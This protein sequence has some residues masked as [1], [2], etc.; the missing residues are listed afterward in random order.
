MSAP[1]LSVIALEYHS[2]A[3]IEKCV[4]SIHKAC[5]NISHE[6]IIS[7][8]SCYNTEKQTALK[9]AYPDVIWLFN[10]KNGGFSYGMNQGLH[11]AQGHYLLTIN[12][13]VEMQNSPEALINFMEA[14][15]DVGIAGPQIINRKG[16]IQDSCRPYVSLPRLISRTFSRI[17]GCNRTGLSR[18]FDYSKTQ[19]VDWVIGAF[20]LIRSNIYQKIGDMDE[21]YFMYAEDLDWCTRTRQLGY[22]TVYHPQTKVVFEGTRRGRHSFKFA[23]IFI[24]SHIHFWRKFGYFGGYPR[25]TS[26]RS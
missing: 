22:E 19:T 3:D 17:L 24:K 15:P 8:N 18:R 4:T 23:H 25:R 16:E 6:I 7:S 11:I 10:A 9:T 14:H 12:L 13:D 20:L 5:G 26:L 2:E 21:H 1:T